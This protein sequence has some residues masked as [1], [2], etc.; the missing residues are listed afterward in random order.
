MYGGC[1]LCPLYPLLLGDISIKEALESLTS[2]TGVRTRTPRA[3]RRHSA[4]PRAAA[5]CARACLS[6]GGTRGTA[7]WLGSYCACLILST[8]SAFAI[9]WGTRTPRAPRIHLN[10]EFKIIARYVMKSIWS[11]LTLE[12]I[13]EGFDLASENG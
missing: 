13:H 12:G 9:V 2:S 8:S 1:L 5:V 3:P 7:I 4:I 6:R 10:N 11:T